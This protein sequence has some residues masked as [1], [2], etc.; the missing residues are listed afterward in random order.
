MLSGKEVLERVLEHLGLTPA[1]FA[2][3]IGLARPQA[4]YDIQKGKTSSVSTRVE[5]N[6]L[7]LKN[8]SCFLVAQPINNRNFLLPLCRELRGWLGSWPLSFLLLI[9]QIPTYRKNRYI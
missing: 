3:K 4:I 5:Y 7:Q 2:N 9:T 8:T 1:A 6:F